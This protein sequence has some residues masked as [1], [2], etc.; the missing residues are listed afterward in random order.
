[1][2]AWDV[3]VCPIRHQ[4]DILAV[5][6]VAVEQPDL[7][8]KIHGSNEDL[9][10]FLGRIRRVHPGLGWIGLVLGSGGRKEG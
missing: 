10:S 7:V 1:L 3:Q 6:I 8:S 4:A 9:G 5:G 2:D